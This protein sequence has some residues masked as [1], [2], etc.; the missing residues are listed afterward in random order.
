MDPGQHA[1]P[2]GGIT[3]NQRERLLAAEMVDDDA[4]TTPGSGQVRLGVAM[5]LPGQRI[6]YSMIAVPSIV[7]VG[8]ASVTS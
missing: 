8:P 7:N 5:R 2:S 3:V 6:W 4:E 1:A